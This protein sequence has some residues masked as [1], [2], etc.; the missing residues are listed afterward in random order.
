M[1]DFALEDKDMLDD[2]SEI[3]S[4]TKFGPIKSNLSIGKD[5][6]NMNRVI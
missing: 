6:G 2:I 5:F 3:F 4:D 1:L